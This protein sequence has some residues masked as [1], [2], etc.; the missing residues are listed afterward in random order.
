MN[1]AATLS[2]AMDEDTLEQLID[3]VRKFVD[4]RLIPLEA[5]VAEEDRI[6][7]EIV[8]EM[9]EMGLFGLTIPQQYGGIGLNTYE[10]CRVVMELGR[11]SPAF[12][13]IF[14]TNNGIGSQGL[15][16]TA[17][18]NRKPTFCRNSPVARS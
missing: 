6:P 16:W 8:Q 10:E 2:P 5:Q 15:V 17:Q 11:T 13:S 1:L 9:R 7:A 18:R 12:R 3:V 4:E 14:G